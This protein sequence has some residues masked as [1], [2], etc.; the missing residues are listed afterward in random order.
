MSNKKIITKEFGC[1]NNITA[2]Q[3]I[4]KDKD[5]NIE[6]KKNIEKPLKYNN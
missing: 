6:I 1:Q 2:N 4:L 5:L 3:N